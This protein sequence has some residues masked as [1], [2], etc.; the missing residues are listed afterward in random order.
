MEPNNFSIL[1]QGDPSSSND[2][3]PIAFTSVLLEPLSPTDTGPSLNLKR[4]RK[5]VNIDSSYV[6]LHNV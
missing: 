2:Y 5:T 6:F 1:M 4:Y 3:H